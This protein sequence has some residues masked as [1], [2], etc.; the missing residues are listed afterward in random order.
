MRRIGI[1]RTFDEQKSGAIRNSSSG[2]SAQDYVV[3][4]VLG[5]STAYMSIT[6][7]TVS[8]RQAYS[9]TTTT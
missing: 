3:V 9:C 7:S 6:A 2:L 5:V 1:N 8:D 4:A